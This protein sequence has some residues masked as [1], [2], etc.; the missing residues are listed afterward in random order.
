MVI[1]NF[2]GEMNSGIGPNP[3]NPQTHFHPKI[4]YFYS[5]PD[6]KG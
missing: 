3:Q 1:A 5:I 2:R 6:K 4:Y